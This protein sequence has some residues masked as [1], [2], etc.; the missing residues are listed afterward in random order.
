MG[1]TL[2]KEITNARSRVFRKAFIKRRL[3][4][5][6]LFESDWV[7]ITEDIKK[8]GKLSAQVDSQ[9]LNKF[10]FSDLKMTLANDEGK[11]ND[12]SNQSS[13]WFGFQDQQRTLVKVH[14]GFVN[15]TQTSDGLWIRQEHPGQSEWDSDD[16]WDQ[17]EWDDTNIV[18]KGVISGDLTI[19]DKNEANLTARPLLQ[20]FRDF[21]A[22]NITGFT[23]TGL[24]ASQFVEAVR[25]MTDGNG[26]YIFLPFFDDTTS[27]WNIS[28]TTV[29]YSNLN[30]AGA[31]DIRDK[32]VWQVINKLAEAENYV[33]YV[34]PSGIFNFIPRGNITSTVAYEF[35]GLNTT[36]TE[37]GHTI[38]QINSFGRRISKAYNRVEL[39]YKEEN[40]T[41]SILSTQTSIEV[42]GG[43]SAWVI[44]QRT[45]QLDN[46]WI[47]DVTTAESVLG[48]V[49]SE[50]SEIKNEIKFNASFVPQVK[51]L[52]RISITYDTSQYAQTSLWDINDW[53]GDTTTDDT[54]TSEYL[55]WDNS[56]GD[57][58]NFSNKEFSVLDVNI[59]LD[60]FSSTFMGR[61]I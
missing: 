4:G 25:D 26:S 5:S 46:T 51:V 7:E 3:I 2:K 24:S 47:P 17:S 48:T 28:T 6:G 57:A 56:K 32:N 19:N 45:L 43:N 33:A 20:L 53:S 35:H 18:F 14:A 8:W 38:K 52:D 31:A 15:E 34:T 50:V 36:D 39:K 42:T 22:N 11:Y 10:T 12:E 55:F 37:F 16:L 29:N 44:G 61:E 49:F 60:K 23:S 21:S 41:T 58:L 40:T 9:R 1:S 13:L 59:D 30:S 54:I 27:N